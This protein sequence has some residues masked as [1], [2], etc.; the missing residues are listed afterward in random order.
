MRNIAGIDRAFYVF[1]KSGLGSGDW[2]S[3]WSGSALLPVFDRVEGKPCSLLLCLCATLNICFKYSL[4]L[5]IRGTWG[6]VFCTRGWAVFPFF[7]TSFEELQMLRDCSPAAPEPWPGQEGLCQLQPQH[8]G[9]K[10]APAPQQTRPGQR[11]PREPLSP[12]LGLLCQGST[13]PPSLACS[14][15]EGAAGAEFAQGSTNTPSWHG[16]A[17]SCHLLPALSQHQHLSAP[18]IKG[19]AA[20]NQTQ[21]LSVTADSC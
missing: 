1:S 17:T 7:C 8:R 14:E 10:A 4:T 16:G 19:E 18:A 15:Q 5:C 21:P 11:A 13:F 12:S 2:S 6:C 20:Q 9:A 3:A